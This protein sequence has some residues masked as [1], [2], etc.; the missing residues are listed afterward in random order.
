M[1]R[2]KSK[3]VWVGL[4]I[5]D[6]VVLEG[7]SYAREVGDEAFD[8][9]EVFASAID[10]M[11]M[12][13][14]IMKSK[15]DIHDIIDQC[16]CALIAHTPHTLT[17]YPG[18]LFRVYLQIAEHQRRYKLKPDSRICVTRW[19]PYFGGPNY[20]RST[21]VRLNGMTAEHFA[22]ASQ[23][24]DLLQQKDQQ[25][26]HIEWYGDFTYSVYAGDN[27]TPPRSM[28]RIFEGTVNAPG[29][30]IVEELETIL[31]GYEAAFPGWRSLPPIK[32]QNP[33]NNLE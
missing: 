25:L 10:D 31:K 21:D 8:T 26:E 12:K 32:A 20:G 19:G 14:R 13:L 2:K 1:K 24:I 17:P 11:R 29:P 6:K 5:G 9:A 7:F 3:I 30:V 22:R 18:E 16:D 28:R 27:K 15:R 23:I 33:A 4:K